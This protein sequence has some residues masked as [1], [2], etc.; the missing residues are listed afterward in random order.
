MF[1]SKNF[2]LDTS[3]YFGSTLFDD[4]IVYNVQNVNLPGID[5][6]HPQIPSR[7]GAYLN[8]TSDQITFNDLQ[9]TILLDE[10]FSIWLKLMAKAFSMVTVPDANFSKNEGDSFILITDSQGNTLL[11][12]WYRNSKIL[13]IGDLNYSSSNDNNVLVLDLALKYDYMD[14]EF[15][16]QLISSNPQAIVRADAVFDLNNKPTDIITTS[17]SET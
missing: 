1:G 3:I 4:E 12:V 13:N 17:S 15:N 2:A 6:S 10:S 16:G 9:L 14:I 8:N 11:K 7:T 5:F